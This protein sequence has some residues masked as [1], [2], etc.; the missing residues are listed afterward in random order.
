[1]SIIET[2]FRKWFVETPKLRSNEIETPKLKTD[3]IICN[4]IKYIGEVTQESL[5]LPIFDETDKDENTW[6]PVVKDLVMNANPA[7]NC[8]FKNVE[9]PTNTGSLKLPFNAKIKKITQPQRT[10]T[11]GDISVGV[12]CYMV[13]YGK[14]SDGSYHYICKS[15]NKNVQQH[16]GP[17]LEWHF[18]NI[19][20][21]PK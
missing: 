5:D 7:G 13:L 17:L 19:E 14:K 18:N 15:I 20:W 2:K 8:A 11:W 9:F 1:M 12:E 10:D 16:Q 21:N 6:Y 4:K 3:E